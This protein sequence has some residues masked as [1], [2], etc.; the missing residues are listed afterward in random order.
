MHAAGASHG[1]EMAADG[2]GVLPLITRTPM[3]IVAI[4]YVVLLM[5]AD[6]QGEGGTLSLLALAERGLGGRR[7]LVLALGLA[8]AAL[9]YGDAALT[10]AVSV[11]SAV[12]GL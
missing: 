2:L 4:K 6:N 8:G 12:E 10:P 5:R 3:L 11:L 9:F 1:G 7:A